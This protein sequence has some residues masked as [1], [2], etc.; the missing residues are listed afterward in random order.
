MAKL[1]AGEVVVKKDNTN[2]FLNAIKALKMSVKVGIPETANSR[3]QDEGFDNMSNAAIGYIQ[4]NGSELAG[5]PP[6]PHLVPGI[7]NVQPQITEEFKKAAQEVFTDPSAVYKRYTRAGILAMNSVKALITSGEGFEKLSEATLKE[8]K[9]AG[10][11]GTKPLL[12]T[13]QYRN[14]IT[15]V[16]AP[17]KGII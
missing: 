11:K 16:I 9:E 14:A 8:R 2:S 17:D 3:P 6:R 1:K 7:R 10:F 15:Y 5:I 13:G 12:R 4:E